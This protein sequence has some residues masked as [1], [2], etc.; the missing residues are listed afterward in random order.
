MLEYGFYLVVMV[1]QKSSPVLHAH[2]Q[3]YFVSFPIK[4]WNGSPP[5]DPSLTYELLWPGWGKRDIPW[6]SCLGLKRH[7]SFHTCTSGILSYQEQKSNLPD[8]LEREAR[9]TEDPGGL[10]E[11]K[12]ERLRK[13]RVVQQTSRITG[14]VSNVGLMPVA[15]VKLLQPLHTKQRQAVATEPSHVAEPWADK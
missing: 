10:Q 9:W 3:F 8:Q 15:L 1:T 2:P 7:R 11:Q 6:L 13:P 12:T 14:H 5:L 4:K